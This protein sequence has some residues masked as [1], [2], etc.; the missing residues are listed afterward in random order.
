MQAAHGSCGDGPVVK[1]LETEAS[2]VLYASAVGE[3]GGPCP[4]VMREQSVQA[5]LGEP[6]SGRVLLDALGRRPVPYGE[7]DGTSPNW[8]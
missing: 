7:P 8:S 6:L 4:A 3:C 5:E 2:V 1:A